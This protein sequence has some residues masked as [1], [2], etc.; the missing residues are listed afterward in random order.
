MDTFA[1][2]LRFF[3][4]TVALRN[5]SLQHAL[6]TPRLQRVILVH[7]IM[8][9]SLWIILQTQSRMNTTSFAQPLPPPHQQ[10]R[11]SRVSTL[12]W[13][14]EEELH[15][16]FKR[17]AAP[18][19]TS[20]EKQIIRHIALVPQGLLSAIVAVFYCMNSCHFTDH[21]PYKQKLNF[22]YSTFFF[23]QEQLLLAKNGFTLF[24]VSDEQLQER[25]NHDYC[26][27][28]KPFPLYH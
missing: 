1:Q 16:I 23:G 12:Y 8:E 27:S 15:R 9:R 19:Q 18:F 10:C 6:Q 4:Q 20:F 28:M 13:M 2:F 14:G 26:M 3:T 24:G 17:I 21:Y 25:Q 22:T 5:R 11:F 7:R